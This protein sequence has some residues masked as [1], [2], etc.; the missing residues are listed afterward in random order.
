MSTKQRLVLHLLMCGL[1]FSL[2]LNIVAATSDTTPNTVTDLGEVEIREYEGKKLSSIDDFRENS[3]RGPQY[4]NK[5]TYR[6]I[7]TGLVDNVLEFTYDEVIN[8]HQSIKKEVSVRCV[9][10]WGV[11]LLWEGVLVKDLIEEAGIDPETT[12]VIFYA[13]DG[14]S[15]SHSLDYIID[16]NI[17]IAYKMNNV[18]LPPERGFPFQL[19]AESKWGYKWIKWITTIELSDNQDYRGFWESAGYSNIGDLGKPFI[20]NVVGP[21]RPDS[22]IPEFSSW[23]L[24]P[25]FLTGTL[26][27]I[28]YRKRL[29]KKG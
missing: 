17:I 8:H 27:T 2:T 26:I 25:I 15:T 19:V 7:I 3:I 13:A 4:I 6:L 29:K 5:E 9:E 18:T 22:I 16:N 21:T 10:G 11:T 1:V 14:Y 28:I 12:T 23:M 24:I 20:E